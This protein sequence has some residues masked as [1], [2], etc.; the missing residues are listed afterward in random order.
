MQLLWVQFLVR[1]KA[2]P[3]KA[4]LQGSSWACSKPKLLQFYKFTLCLSNFKK[5]YPNNLNNIQKLRDV[6]LMVQMIR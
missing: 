3:L 6:V 5:H 1:S 4:D 2:E